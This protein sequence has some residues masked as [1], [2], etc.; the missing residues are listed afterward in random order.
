MFDEYSPKNNVDN[1]L[2]AWATTTGPEIN[3]GDI[4]RHNTTH[5]MDLSTDMQPF[6]KS[7]LLTPAREDPTKE[8][9]DEFME[10]C[11][12]VTLNK[13]LNSNQ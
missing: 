13:R 5:I 4:S 11:R 1:G 8:E 12:P 10:T 9:D 3:V 6:K 2:Q 7:L